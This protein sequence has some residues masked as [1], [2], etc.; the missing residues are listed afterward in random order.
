MK[1]IILSTLDFLFARKILLPINIFF[2]KLIIRFI[3]YNNHN[4]ISS[5]GEKNFLDKIMSNK[6]LLCIDVG[7]NI[8]EYSKYILENSNSK[9]IA[10]EPMPE[11]FKKLKKIKNTFSDRFYPYNI[12]IGKKNETKKLNYDSNNLQWANFNPE[13]KKI[14]YL[15]NNKKSVEC[16]ISTLDNFLFRDKKHLLKNATH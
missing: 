12:G 9:V 3:G 16:K 8:G 11:S 7:A 14:D 5:S 1:K 15:K 13:L 4:N 10:F 2:L 6:A